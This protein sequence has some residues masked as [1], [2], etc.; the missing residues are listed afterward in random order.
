MADI[1]INALATTAAST[2]SDDFVAVDGSANGTRKLNAYSPTFGGNLTVSGTLNLT[3]NQ[4]TKFGSQPAFVGD[5]TTF[6]LYSGG[7]GGYVFRNANDTSTLA[8]LSNAGNLT[9]SGTGTSTFSGPIKAQVGSGASQTTL[10]NTVA[11]GGGVGGYG[12]CIGFTSEGETSGTVHTGIGNIRTGGYDRSDLAFYAKAAQTTGNF[13]SS[14]EVARFVASSGNFLIGKTTPDSGQKLQVSGSTFTTQNY[15]S[16]ASNTGL[17]FTGVNDDYTYGVWRDG[18]NNIKVTTNNVT[19]LTLDASQNATFAKSITASGP[20]TLSSSTQGNANFYAISTSASANFG[21]LYEADARTQSANARWNWGTGSTDGG[22][23]ADSFR[24]RERVTGV[25]TLVISA[26]T[27]NATFAGAVT[28]NGNTIVSGN[29][30][31]SAQ[32]RVDGVSSGYSIMTWAWDASYKWHAGMTTGG[33]NWSIGK[34]TAVSTWTPYL[35]LDHSTGNATFAGSLTTSA[36][37]GGAG[38]W[39]L[40]VYSATAP[41]ATGYVTIEI[42]GVQY[43]LLA[44]T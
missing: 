21:A 27:G 44:S 5:G 28:A 18:S 43:K 20:L 23:A 32:L 1:R 7:T 13:S 10:V 15:Y 17:F 41:T 11:I 19:A 24:I 12:A 38:A 14:D 42:G 3:Q 25:N 40:G 31:N 36:P 4:Q 6:Y 35:T 39:E 33:N 22:A 2:A 8:S 9:V 37:T 16:G 30:N 26:V 34:V 29:G